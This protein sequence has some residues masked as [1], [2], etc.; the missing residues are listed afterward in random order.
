MRTTSERL[1]RCLCCRILAG[2]RVGRSD[3]ERA[4]HGTDCLI[5]VR[6]KRGPQTTGG[7]G[8]PSKQEGQIPPPEPCLSPQSRSLT[9]QLV[10][11][12]P[13]KASSFP[14]PLGARF[15]NAVRVEPGR[16]F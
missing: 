12:A 10:N 3:P 13:L 7:D 5:H 16:P 15:W 6:F 1:C 9:D 14:L 8:R 11:Y 2:E 4:D